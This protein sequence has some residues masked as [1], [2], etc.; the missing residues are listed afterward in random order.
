M[1][2]DLPPLPTALPAW[3]VRRPTAA[4]LDAVLALAEAVDRA[5]LGS[6]VEEAFADH[7]TTTRG[8]SRRGGGPSGSPTGATALYRSEGMD[9]DFAMRVLQ[10]PVTGG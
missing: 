5:T 8:S 9:V 6:V 3:T 10:R 7:W 1:P 4:D 2:L